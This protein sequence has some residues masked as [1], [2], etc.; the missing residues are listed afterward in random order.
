MC[1]DC[2]QCSGEVSVAGGSEGGWRE[3]KVRGSQLQVLQGLWFA[4]SFPLR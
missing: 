2:L 1:L 3:M 4:I